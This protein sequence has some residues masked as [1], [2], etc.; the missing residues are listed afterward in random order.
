MHTPM[1]YTPVIVGQNW[2]NAPPMTR[3]QAKPPIPGEVLCPN[4]RNV[5]PADCPGR[6]ATAFDPQ[7][8]T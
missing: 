4:G 2:R 6:P 1:G 3:D 8:V 7:S 5:Q